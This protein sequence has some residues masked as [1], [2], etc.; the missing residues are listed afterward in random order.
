MILQ[1]IVLPHWSLRALLA[2][3]V[4]AVETRVANAPVLGVARAVAAAPRVRFQ[5]DGAR[6]ER[7]IY[8]IKQ[9][10]T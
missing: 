3:A 2:P 4:T 10:Y 5:I 1:L 7:T 8:S 9:E 6:S